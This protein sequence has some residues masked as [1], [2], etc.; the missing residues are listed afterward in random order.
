MN[1]YSTA[2]LEFCFRFSSAEEGSALEIPQYGSHQPRVA[3]EP[4]RR[5][6]SALIC[7]VSKQVQV[8]KA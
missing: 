3:T 1:Y 8:L 2:R 5:G 7:A 4:L 6:H